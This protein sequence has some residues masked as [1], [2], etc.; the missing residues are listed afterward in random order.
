MRKEIKYEISYKEYKNIVQILDRVMTRDSHSNENGEYSIRSIYFD[1]HLHEVENKKLN[2]INSL[3]KYRIRMYNN[4]DSSI[5][6][7]R[8]SNEN[9][10]ME[11]FKQKIDKQDVINILE[12]KISRNIGR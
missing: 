11:K 12:R 4:D 7:E 5:F 9:S 10:F 3:K 8:K 6:L 2:D 1:N